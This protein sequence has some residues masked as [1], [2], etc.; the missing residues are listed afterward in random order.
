VGIGAVLDELAAVGIPRELVLGIPQGYRMTGAVKEAERRLGA[1]ML[2][3][4]A[5]ELMAWCIGNAKIIP[6]GNAVLITKQVSGSAKID[7]LLALI[8]A[9]SLMMLNPAIARLLAGDPS[10]NALTALKKSRADRS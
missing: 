3:H 6:A 10:H 4:G 1:A 9:V 2:W 5:L 7:P 8:D